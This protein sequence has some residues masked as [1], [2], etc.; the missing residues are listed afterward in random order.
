MRIPAAALTGE[1]SIRDR[2]P[3][4]VD[5]LNWIK[6][7][8]LN[9]SYFNAIDTPAQSASAIGSHTPERL[10]EAFLEGLPR[11]SLQAIESSF[12]NSPDEL[13]TAA[14]LEESLSRLEQQEAQTGLRLLGRGNIG[15]FQE[16]AGPDDTRQYNKL[17][18]AGGLRYPLLGRY[19]QNKLS[20]L[21]AEAQTWEAR[22]SHRQ[23]SLEALASVRAHYINLWSA[24]EKI[25]LSRT[26]LEKEDGVRQFLENR[27]RSGHL[28]DADRQ[29]FL[30]AFS[31]VR[32]NIAVQRSIY[33]R[34]FRG[35]RLLTRP[36]FPQFL[37]NF[38]ELP[39]P[40]RKLDAL[41]SYLLDR[42]P[43]INLHRGRVEKALGHLKIEHYGALEG[44]FD[45]GGYLAQ[46]DTASKEEYGITLE[47]QV[48]LPLRWRDAND[49]A[50]AAHD[51]GLKKAQSN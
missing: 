50:K 3:N 29:E 24:Q 43:G 27:T 10:G 48:D 14:R 45:L 46:E 15:N 34:S 42:H 13:I 21:D 51:A 28:L 37:A 9:R 17:V 33:G 4:S 6:R 8:S 41:R 16:L 1:N 19:E 25:R 31:A 35:I 23:S 22:L 12:G 30:T 49:A 44:S 11:R 38:P 32:R 20:V 7:S 26:F 40:C 36:D 5:P 2:R 47:I 18:V 39:E